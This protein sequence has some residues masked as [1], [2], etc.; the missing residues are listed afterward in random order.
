MER[1]VCILPCFG[2][3]ICD[4]ISCHS[5]RHLA[6]QPTVCQVY[7]C[8]PYEHDAEDANDSSRFR[9]RHHQPLPVR[10]IAVLVIIAGVIS[11]Q[12][13]T[14]V[15]TCVVG[16]QPD[17][18]ALKPSCVLS[19]H[20]CTTGQADLLFEAVWAVI[21]LLYYLHF[22]ARHY[23]RMGSHDSTSVL[24]RGVL[25]LLDEDPGPFNDFRQIYA[26]RCKQASRIKN[27]ELHNLA[28]RLFE[29]ES[30][31]FAVKA[32]QFGDMPWLSFILVYSMIQTYSVWLD[33]SSPFW[34]Y[35]NVPQ[36]F[37]FG[38][39][40]ALVLLLLPVLARLELPRGRYFRPIKT[41]PDLTNI[42]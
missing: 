39:V 18:W 29:F 1:H 9:E 26:W 11:L 38:Q 12:V 27:R 14:Q 30:A 35:N 20:L 6:F 21:L 10:A 17:H 19:N 25:L 34:K 2:P 13:I 28:Q 15:G 16:S 5:F 33:K 31:Y 8:P 41:S 37:G 42:H 7:F 4:N 3:G 40:T 32:S 36:V 22:M 23:S 24:Y